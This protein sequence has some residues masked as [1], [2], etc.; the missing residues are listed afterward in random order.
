M[1]PAEIAEIIL[2]GSVAR[3]MRGP[4]IMIKMCMS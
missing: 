1:L 3:K 2:A 4:F